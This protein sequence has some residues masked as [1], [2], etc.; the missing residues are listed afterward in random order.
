VRVEN[1]IM[2]LLAGGIAEK[3]HFGRWNHV[4]ASSDHYAAVNLAGYLTPSIEETQAYVKW[5]CIRTERMLTQP[6]Q[7]LMVEAVAEALL[8]RETLSVM[9]ARRIM[10]E[11]NIQ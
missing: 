8:E 4:C 7:W 9:A 6:Q 11:A 2:A 5:L 3:I 1:E 10:K